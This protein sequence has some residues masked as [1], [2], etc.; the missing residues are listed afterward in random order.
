MKIELSENTVNTIINLLEDYL[1][2][3]INIFEDDVQ[4]MVEV[5]KA[6]GELQGAVRA[7]KDFEYLSRKIKE[8]YPAL[9]NSLAD[10]MEDRINEIA[11]KELKDEN[12]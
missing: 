4:L 5:A 11:L 6:L 10:F 2:G 8:D 1:N 3:R 9:D 7:V 12:I